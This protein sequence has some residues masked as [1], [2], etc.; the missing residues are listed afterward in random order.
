MKNGEGNSFPSKKDMCYW[1]IIAV[2]AIV[3]V[4]IWRVDNPD[5]LAG[6]LSLG[7]AL[8]SMLLAVVGIIIPFIQG[9]ETSR[10]N[11]K[12]LEHISTLTKEVAL[13]SKLANTVELAAVKMAE[14][15]KKKQEVE[16]KS[17]ANNNSSHVAITSEGYMIW[18]QKQDE[19]NDLKRGISDLSS[20]MTIRDKGSR[21][22]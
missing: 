21:S 6:Q 13:Y 9:N 19:I 12:L 15:L 8:L 10:Q 17:N 3:V 22:G 1:L 7:A 20:S 14:E 16:S 18:Q 2:L 5:K 4:S 11:F